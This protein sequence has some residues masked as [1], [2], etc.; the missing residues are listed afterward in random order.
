M[1]ITRF[2]LAA[3]GPFTGKVLEFPSNRVDLHVI[4]GANEAGKSSS[5][6]AL[7]AWLFGFPERTRDD[8]IHPRTSLLVGGELSREGQHL[9]FY[10]RKKRKGD[11]VDRDGAP[12]DPT[13]LGPFLGGLDAAIFESLHAIDHETLVQGGRDILARRGE[14]GETLFSAGAGLGSLHKALERMESEKAE[15]YKV[16]GKNQKINQRIR[17]HKTLHREIRELSC[18]P[19]EWQRQADTLAR[20]S[21]ELE[22]M[23]E[24]RRQ[25]DRQRAHCERL[26]RAAPLFARRKSI[27]H[28]LQ[29]LGTVR[30]LPPDFGKHRNALQQQLRS[31]RQRFDLLQKRKELILAELDRLSPQT[32]VVTRSAQIESLYQRLGA[33]KK[34][35]EDRPHRAGMRAVLRKEAAHLLQSIMPDLELDDT[36][37]LVPL[38]RQRRKILALAAEYGAQARSRRDVELRLSTLREE[39]ERTGQELEDLPQPVSG[40]R[41]QAAVDRALK[42]GDIDQRIDGLHQELSTTDKSLLAAVQRLGHWRKGVDSLPNAQL[43]PV[44]VIRRFGAAR[45]ELARQEQQFAAQAEEI[46]DELLRLKTRMRELAQGGE[47]VTEKELVRI[48]KRR[49]KGWHLLCRQW[50]LGEDIESALRDFAPEGELHE[51]VF[52]LIQQADNIG[53]RLRLEADRVQAFVSL[54]AREDELI[55]RK[56]DNEQAQKQLTVSLVEHRENWHMLWQPLAIVPGTPDEMAEWLSAMEKIQQQA[57]SLVLR[58]E[59]L[60]RMQQ[61]RAQLRQAVVDNLAVHGAEIP[62]GETLEPVLTSARSLL[63]EMEQARRHHE[64]IGL[65]VR[66]QK[67]QVRQAERE[68]DQIEREQRQWQRR[69]HQL[70]TLGDRD[71]SFAPDEAQDFFDT[72]ADIDTRL[73]EAAE[74]ESRIQ[75]IDRDGAEFER[76]VAALAAEVA[77][78]LKGSGVEQ[79]VSGLY[80]LMTIAGREQALHVQYSRELRTNTGELAESELV[81]QDS[82]KELDTL[83]EL[84]GCTKEEELIRAEQKSEEHARLNKQLRRLE[85]DLQQI[86]G[87]LSLD[88]LAAEVDR[89]DCDAL[90]G[91]IHALEQEISREVDPALQHLAEQK[92]EARKML[93]QMDGS[94]RAARKAE[95]LQGNLA[96]LRQDAQRYL[97][98]QVGVDLLRREIEKFRR[99]NQGPVLTRASGIFAEL[100]LGSFSGLKTDVDGRG[101][102]VL[103]GIRPDS[104]LPID[105]AAMSTG[106]R[107][108]LYL[109]LRLASLVHRAEQGRPM[110]SVFDDILINFDDDR[111]TATLKVLAEL[112]GENQLILFT[113]QRHVARQAER[114]DGVQV[115]YLEQ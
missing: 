45:E 108:Q 87:E 107:D 39:L 113:H 98:L 112:D 13:L 82:R 27:H 33:Y 38:V 30:S 90:P 48:R 54:Q 51:V 1:R 35:R 75:G 67:V 66:Q 37:V 111:S 91:D 29:E 40:T 103:V 62:E 56:E 80:D 101:E 14:L 97:R 58:R 115:H 92:G 96:H 99:K 86:A 22:Q 21:R 20:L 70:A 32:A 74:F 63:A 72:I 81:L 84:A 16:R 76:E 42:E 17:R 83:L 61:T 43:V 5:L 73:K 53:D 55:R 19:E 3:F 85:Q 77:P 11:I 94:G 18:A 25:L 31:E 59:E 26:L 50:L 36:R 109:A 104:P 41:L 24:R 9:E 114:I 88:E 106:S 49:D 46:R 78:D 12:L 110:A 44:A 7:R 10:R 4:Y 23:Q 79:I 47:V 64:Q 105:V 95:D 8:F 34:A 60:T 28:Q 6:R 69:W 15:L 100:T 65:E 102:P 52:S 89:V 68:L 2:E 71:F 57:S 93:E